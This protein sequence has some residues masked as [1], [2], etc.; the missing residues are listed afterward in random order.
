[1]L[2][3]GRDPKAYM[4]GEACDFWNRYEEDFA[5]S[6]QLGHNTSRFGV[7]WSRIEP[8]EGQFDEKAIDHYE[9]ILRAAKF[10]QLT[11]FLTLHHFTVP[12]WFAKKGGF[13]KRAN[14]ERF[15]HFVQKI[16]PRFNE[17]TRGNRG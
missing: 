6:A 16:A 11:V 2:A 15:I 5:L 14:T 7:E 1:M 13:A 3:R 10:H 12:L 9:K 17:K 8:Q 4:S